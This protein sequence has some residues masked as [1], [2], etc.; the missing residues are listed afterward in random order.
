MKE[1][2]INVGERYYLKPGEYEIIEL[3]N[4]GKYG[5]TDERVNINGLREV[6][7]LTVAIGDPQ[8]YGNV[9]I[10]GEDLKGMGDGYRELILE[11]KNED[12]LMPLGSPRNLEDLQDIVNGNEY[13]PYY[14]SWITDTV[15]ELSRE[16]KLILIGKS[17]KRDLYFIDYDH[18]NF[19]V[20]DTQEK[21]IRNL[22]NEADNLFG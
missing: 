2:K 21:A 11:I 20:Y 15:L 10:K 7:L 17:T 1:H 6:I 19:K 3:L 18:T 14:A 4:S 9:L 5:N 22:L 16:D 13:S 12:S 8:I